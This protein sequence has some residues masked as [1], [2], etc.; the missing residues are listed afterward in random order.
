MGQ[1]IKTATMATTEDLQYMY[2]LLD[3]KVPGLLHQGFGYVLLVVFATYM[4]AFIQGFLVGKAREKYKVELPTMYS[5]TEQ[6]FNCYQRVHQNTL[7]RVPLF[8][9]ILLLAALFNSIIAA[10]IGAIWVA[11]RVIYSILLLWGPKQQDRWFFDEPSGRLSSSYHGLHSC[12]SDGRLVGDRPKLGDILSTKN[13]RSISA[14]RS[15]NV[16]R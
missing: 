3:K 16:F 9:A 8:L 1:S 6:M 13:M 10:V 14:K 12:G 15:Q 2:D 4:V 7:E 5:D 11:G